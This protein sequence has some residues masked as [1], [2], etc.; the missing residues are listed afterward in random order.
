VIESNHA[1][2][3]DM[4]DDE[5]NARARGVGLWG[6]CGENH[7]NERTDV[8]ICATPRGGPV[9]VRRAVLCANRGRAIG[10]WVLGYFSSHAIS[11][12]RARILALGFSL[13]CC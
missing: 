2:A 1:H 11:T 10:S 8:P 12:D 13:R 7:D 3:R 6:A 9:S 5:L 4:L